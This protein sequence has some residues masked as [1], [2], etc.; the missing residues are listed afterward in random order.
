[1]DNMMSNDLL[2]MEKM[3]DDAAS[4][5]ICGSDQQS[6]QA[7]RTTA[8]C[9]DHSLLALIQ[10]HLIQTQRSSMQVVRFMLNIQ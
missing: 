5:G 1:M 3:A 9:L 8:I 10:Q 7:R 4:I 6:L 2:D